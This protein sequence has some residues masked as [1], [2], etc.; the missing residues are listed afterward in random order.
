MI[1]RILVL[2]LF[3]ASCAHAPDFRKADVPGLL[4]GLSAE[5]ERADG[6]LGVAKGLTEA[7]CMVRE[8]PEC[9][10]ARNRLDTAADAVS[11]ARSAVHEAENLHDKFWR[12]A[13]ATESAVAA[14]ADALAAAKALP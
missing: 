3:L 14:A 6:A 1:W 4:K 12:A 8:V 10:T 7:A 13:D 5:I 2:C 9:A 11:R